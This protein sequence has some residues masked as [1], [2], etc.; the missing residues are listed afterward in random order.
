M[1]KKNLWIAEEL[2]RWIVDQL[3]SPAKA[4]DFR[5]RSTPHQPEA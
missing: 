4:A 2:L 5:L 3:R 1:E